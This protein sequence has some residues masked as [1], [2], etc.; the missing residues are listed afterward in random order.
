MA[1]KSNKYDVFKNEMVN[2]EPSVVQQQPTVKPKADVNPDLFK[3]FAI[4]AFGEFKVDKT[5]TSMVHEFS[6]KL[7]DQKHLTN[8]HQMMMKVKHPT[9]VRANVFCKCLDIQLTKI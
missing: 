6:N 8:G 1:T 4:A 9:R 2:A 3:D 7:S 5:S